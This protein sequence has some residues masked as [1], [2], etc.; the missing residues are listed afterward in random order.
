MN[1]IWICS[2]EEFKSLSYVL[3]D[4]II[5]MDKIRES[6]VNKGDKMSMLY[7]YL[8]SN[9]FKLQV[10]GIVEG[11]TQMQND[12]QREKNAM[13]KIWN[14]REKQISKVLLNT[15]SMYGSIQGLAGNSISNIDALEMPEQD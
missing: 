14:Q 3:R 12:L 8:T 4:S 13:Q 15:S 6:Q 10:E 11:F 5:R 9:E 7:E 2:F 1:G